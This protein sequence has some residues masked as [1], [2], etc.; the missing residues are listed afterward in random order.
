M[1]NDDDAEE[2]HF[3]AILKSL[4]EKDSSKYLRLKIKINELLFINPPEEGELD[5]NTEVLPRI[6]L[7]HGR[8]RNDLESIIESINYK[9]PIENKKSRI[10]EAYD[11]FVNSFKKDDNIRAAGY[12]DVFESV[13][14]K[15]KFI[16]IEI[17]EVPD[18]FEVF[19]SINNSG[20]GLTSSDLLKN[21]VEENLDNFFFCFLNAE[22]KKS[23]RSSK[24]YSENNFSSF[25]RKKLEE[26]TNLE[27][28]LEKVVLASKIYKQILNPEA[29]ET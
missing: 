17:E 10:F 22:Y 23:G 29:S 3:V 16:L 19:E 21:V 27:K 6:E 8:D 13:K 14:E 26:E 18:V 7:H 12:L 1:S 24:H 15:L 28:L 5:V 9:K 2:M 20:K 4:E 25:F 11:Y